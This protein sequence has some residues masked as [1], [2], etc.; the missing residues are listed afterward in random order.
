MV[1]SHIIVASLSTIIVWVL[2]L[3]L[4]TLLPPKIE[5]ADYTGLAIIEAGYW[6][7]NVP[8]GLP[9]NAPNIPAGFAVVVQPDNKVVHSFGDTTCRA[10]KQLTEC[11]PEIVASQPGQRFLNINGEKWAEVVHPL[12]GGERVIARFGPPRVELAL[13]APFVGLI[14]GNVPYVT[15]IATVTVL[16][17]IP[18]ALLLAWLLVRPL[19][20]RVKNVAR[21]SQRFATGDLQ[22]RV[23][24]RHPDEVGEMA[25]QFDDMADT[26]EQNVVVLRDLV[27]RNAELTA[28]AEQAAIQAERVRLSR[29]L[30]DDIAQR[31]FSLSVSSAGLPATIEREPAQAVVQAQAIAN[32]A[33]QTLLELRALLVELRPSQ[34][35]QHGLSQALKDLCDDWSA[36]HCIPVN[37]A[38]LFNGQRLPAKVEDTIYR[39][40]QESLNNIAKH[41]QASAVHVSLVQGKKQITLSATDDGRG[42]DPDASG[43]EHKFGIISMQER[44]QAVGGS[45]AI[46]SDTARGTTVRL[47]LPFERDTTL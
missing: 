9:N 7:A 29:D 2:I 46:E 43:A 21:A 34:V 25:R 15:Y 20:R 30:H 22:T 23:K 6:Q 38:I 8:D 35:V 37:C 31:I 45:L 33:E 26:L 18:V 28:Q 32:L 24:D 5:P 11:A 1:V 14:N 27:E 41:A 10:G 12:R 17:S 42:F 36:A 16:L 3:G 47:T 40:A 19:L 13:N 39:V 4:L 44:A